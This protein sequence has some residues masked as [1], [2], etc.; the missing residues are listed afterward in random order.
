MYI[1]KLLPYLSNINHKYYK[2]SDINF[3]IIS[4][5]DNKFLTIIYFYRINVNHTKSFYIPS[6][7]PCA[8]LLYFK[9]K[10]FNL[11]FTIFCADEYTLIPGLTKKALKK[12]VVN[13]NKVNLWWHSRESLNVNSAN[14]YQ[15]LFF[16]LFKY[17]IKSV[18]LYLSALHRIGE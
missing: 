2:L 14:L 15:L 7:L 13:S 1:S 9:K 3:P 5:I 10:K 4:P 8:L 6:L 17:E 18:F 12:M 11:F 16:I